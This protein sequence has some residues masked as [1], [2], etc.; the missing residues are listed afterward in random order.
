M[1]L[2][3][4]AKPNSP[5]GA[6][7][8]AVAHDAQQKAEMEGATESLAAAAKARPA[9]LL[10]QATSTKLAQ[11]QADTIPG[12]TVVERIEW[13]LK[14]LSGQ[15]AQEDVAIQIL[16]QL[17]AQI[18][19]VAD[20]QVAALQRG[21]LSATIRAMRV[22]ES[23]VQVQLAGCK[24][25][26]NAVACEETSGA[27]WEEIGRWTGKFA[28]GAIEVLVSALRQHHA[29]SEELLRLG[30]R[31]LSSICRTDELREDAM[32]SGAEDGWLAHGPRG[33]APGLHANQEKQKEAEK[34]EATLAVPKD[35]ERPVPL[36]RAPSAPGF[37]PPRM[38]GESLAKPTA[39]ALENYKTWDA[40]APV[41]E[42]VSPQE[43]QMEIFRA[44]DKGDANAVR[45]L[46][47]AS[48]GI[49]INVTVED[50][51]WM[52]HKDGSNRPHRRSQA[53]AMLTLLLVAARGG[54]SDVIDTLLAA[55][56]DPS[57]ASANY[58][59]AIVLA[60][61]SG[62]LTLVR[63]LLEHGAAIDARD[64]RGATALIAATFAGGL[65][66]MRH[67]LEHG[68]AVGAQAK[69]GM[70][71]L[72]AAAFH[73][74]MDAIN[75]LLEH[76]ADV[77]QPAAKKATAPMLATQSGKWKAVLRLMEAGG[78]P[79]MRDANGE[80]A[81]DYASA[82]VSARKQRRELSASAADDLLEKLQ[83]ALGKAPPKFGENA[84][85][86][87]SATGSL[88]GASGSVKE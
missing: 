3:D 4:I 37:N 32:H 65:A 50:N 14:L 67:L 71:A 26:C 75:L 60:A 20:H 88:A 13:L 53:P 9:A 35:V 51:S 36:N 33:A 29:S 25:I 11:L 57:V 45:G 27:K 21:V 62:D 10:R 46:I 77:N 28:G 16:D 41:G 84:T 18:G 69:D 54:H 6:Q 34:D 72:G 58:P 22:H 42:A 8:A 68:A 79:D 49:D 55:G 30:G 70:H 38:R 47:N 73:G 44:V 81:L 19:S 64:P 56:A 83:T 39:P 66:I 7:Q 43:V 15:R 59:P 63:R 40:A 85:R 31:A 1:I 74:N 82:H 2:S 87:R 78:D 61:F 76:G 5:G 23:K 86:Q 12:D 24:L 48:A 52:I 17:S 80:T